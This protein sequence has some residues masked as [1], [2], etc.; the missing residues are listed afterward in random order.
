M[1]KLTNMLKKMYK[2]SLLLLFFVSFG[3]VAQDNMVNE[4]G[5]LIKKG[6]AE[7]LSNLFEESVT[8]SILDSEESVSRQK[9]GEKI[10]EFFAKFPIKIFK[11][12]HQGTSKDGKTFAIGEYQSEDAVFRTYVVLSGDKIQEI[13]FE[14]D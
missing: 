3:L 14:E 6:D 7:Q 11:Q 2:S 9:A 4:I 5:D 8:L 13:C 1:G 10:K 12:K